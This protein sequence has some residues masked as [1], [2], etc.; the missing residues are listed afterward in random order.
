MKLKSST[1]LGLVVLAG[2]LSLP[3]CAA[4]QKIPENIDFLIADKTVVAEDK[5][6]FKNYL[7]KAILYG[8]GRKKLVLRDYEKNIPVATFTAEDPDGEGPKPF[9]INP[10][11][12]ETSPEGHYFNSITPSKAEEIFKYIF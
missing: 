3:G 11:L 2:S 1:S 8:S 7:G 5:R 9:E 4:D 10:I 12:F 6:V